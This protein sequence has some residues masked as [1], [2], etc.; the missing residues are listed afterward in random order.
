MELNF[1]LKAAVKIRVY[2]WIVIY[3]LHDNKLLFDYPV[4]LGTF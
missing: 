3:I 1:H 4:Y 2:C